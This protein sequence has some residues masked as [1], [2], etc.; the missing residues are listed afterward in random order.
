[1][2]PY[3]KEPETNVFSTEKIPYDFSK[4]YGIIHFNPFLLR[5]WL[6]TPHHYVPVEFSAHAIPAGVVFCAFH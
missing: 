2:K 3:K 1:M 6:P 5:T 4:S